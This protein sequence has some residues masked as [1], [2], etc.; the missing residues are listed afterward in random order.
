MNS[1]ILVAGKYQGRRNMQVLESLIRSIRSAATHNPDVQAAPACILWPDGDR[2]WETIIPRLQSQMPELLRLGDYSPDNR[3]GPA[4]WMRCVI[5]NLMKEVSIPSGYTPVL[6]LPGFTRQDLRAVE[7]CPDAL[8]PLAELQF[9]GVIWSQVNAKDWTVLAYLK[10]NQGGLGLDVAQDMDAKQAMLL[11]LFRILDEDVEILCGRH[12]DRDYFNTLLSGG[13]PVRDLLQWLDQG[14]AFKAARDE[15]TWRGF[16]EVCKSQLGFDPENDGPLKAAALLAYRK[17]AWEGVWGRF[18]E[19]PTRY[20]NVPSWLRKTSPPQDLYEDRSAWP[21]VNEKA[22]LSLRQTLAQLAT[23]TPQDARKKILLAESEHGVR[24]DQVWAELKESPL[25]QALQHLAVV[26]KVTKQSLA[27]GDLVDM[28]AAYQAAGW[29]A[30]AAAI[31]AI[32]CVQK[33]DDMK[34][35]ETALQTVYLP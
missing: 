31:A 8:K 34:A 9:R 29:A 17:G 23:S 2:Q 15:N 11:S 32:G 12:L 7:T 4:I 21:Q 16:V 24:R 1:R 22:E 19:A 30:D 33:P 28:A 3:I 26:A 5:A 10:S 13:D 20:L 6:Y 14:D 35:V 25:A 18:C 27:A